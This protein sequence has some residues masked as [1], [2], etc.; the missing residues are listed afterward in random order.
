MIKYITG[1]IFDSEVSALVNTVN[2]QGVMGKGIALQ[3][4]ERYPN[5]YRLYRDACK[6]GDVEVGTMFITKERE[7]SGELRTIINFPT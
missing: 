1:N 3:F 7:M 4:K 5:N 2:T 6:R